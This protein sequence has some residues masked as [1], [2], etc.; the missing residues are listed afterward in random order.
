MLVDVISDVISNV[1]LLEVEVGD[2]GEVVGEVLIDVTN[3]FVNGVDD[4]M[5]DVDVLSDSSNGVDLIVGTVV[6]ASAAGEGVGNVGK[7]GTVV[8]VVLRTIVVE[9]SIVGDVVEAPVLLILMA[10]GAFPESRRSSTAFQ[11]T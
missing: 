3:G 7:E 11:C 1:M 2:A 4:A 8:G 5:F 9:A 6:P 10:A